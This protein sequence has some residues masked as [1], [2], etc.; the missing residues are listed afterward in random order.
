[1][2]MKICEVDCVTVR[3]VAKS[4]IF[5]KRSSDNLSTKK[6]CFK[7]LPFSSDKLV[8]LC[9]N[10]ALKWRDDSTVRR[11]ETLACKSLVTN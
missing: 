3:E 2:M 6:M 9:A 5:L 4:Y 1:M 7:F 10:R 8:K 11:T